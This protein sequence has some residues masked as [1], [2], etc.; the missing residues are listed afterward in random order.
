MT[1]D[2]LLVW[3][4]VNREGLIAALIEGT[5]Q[6]KTVRGVEIPKPGGGVRQLGI[7]TPCRS[8]SST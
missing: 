2:D 4:A 7:P 3:I 1:V 6:P 8:M 5:Y